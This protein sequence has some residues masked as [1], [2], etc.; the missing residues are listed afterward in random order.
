MLDLDGVI[1][2]VRHRLPLLRGARKDWN[3]F[4]AAA[5]ADPPLPEGLAVAQRLAPDHVVV[6]LTGRPERCR[7]DTERWLR[8]HG[9]PAGELHMRRDGD[10]RPARLAKLEVLRTLR[11]ANPVAVLVDDDPVVCEAARR[12]GFVVLEATWALDEAAD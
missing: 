3:A 11:R 10:R 9:L 7:E 5:P 12:A 2:D 6:Y 8:A 1:A 4:F